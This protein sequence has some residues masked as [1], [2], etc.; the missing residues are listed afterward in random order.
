MAIAM[1]H[2]ILV[3]GAWVSEQRQFYQ[4][5]KKR[6][7]PSHLTQDRIDEMNALGFKWE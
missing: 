6:D 2:R 4:V 3:L 7:V 5:L 1:Y